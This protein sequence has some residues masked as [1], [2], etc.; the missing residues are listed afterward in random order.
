MAIFD[1]NRPRFGPS[2]GVPPARPITT[3]VAE[4]SNRM[5]KL[6]GQADDD[7]AN[8]DK[9]PCPRP[10]SKRPRDKTFSPTRID[11]ISN[12]PQPGLG[13]NHLEMLQIQLEDI[14]L[15]KP[16]VLLDY[17]SPKINGSSSYS[18]ILNYEE[19]AKCQLK[20][21]PNCFT[22]NSTTPPQHKSFYWVEFPP[23]EQESGKQLQQLQNNEKPKL[24]TQELISYNIV[25]NSNN[26][27]V[28]KP[29]AFQGGL[30]LLWDNSVE[31]EADHHSCNIIHTSV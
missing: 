26:P 5:R 17:P 15:S 1:P 23:E 6:K 19:I 18:V 11:L 2:L 27:S 30:A 10:Q 9:N 31:L 21:Q 8:K 12:L 16:T 25:S 29:E 22:V 4:N 28:S 3:I 24:G 7:V 13:P 14:G 20:C